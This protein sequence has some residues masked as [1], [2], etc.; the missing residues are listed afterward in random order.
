MSLEEYAVMA[1]L[2]FL[3]NTF[4][5]MGYPFVRRLMKR[6]TKSATNRRPTK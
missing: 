6:S 3:T 5:L 4:A 1:T 2:L